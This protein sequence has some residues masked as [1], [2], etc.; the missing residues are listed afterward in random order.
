MNLHLVDTDF[1]HTHLHYNTESMLEYSQ[2]QGTVYPQTAYNGL[3]ELMPG[4]QRTC[5]PS[6]SGTEESTWHAGWLAHSSL[7]LWWS[8]QLQNTSWCST[9]GTE[10]NPPTE[11]QWTALYQVFIGQITPPI[12]PHCGTGEETAKHLLLLCPKWAAEHQ[13]YFGDSTADVFQD[14]D[15]QKCNQTNNTIYGK[16]VRQHPPKTIRLKIYQLLNNNLKTQLVT[17]CWNWFWH[18]LFWTRFDATAC[19]TR[20]FSL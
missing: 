5:F 20:A 7:G 14:S 9:A 6:P 15:N 1:L 13:R 10:S 19:A 18:I 2:Q 11:A 17:T 16:N 8:T 12:C 3:L 4:L